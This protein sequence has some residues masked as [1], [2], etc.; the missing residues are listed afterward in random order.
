[1]PRILEALNAGVQIEVRQSRHAFE[2]RTGK[3][4]AAKFCQC[5]IK[6]CL[7]GPAHYTPALT[8]RF[9]Q[10]FRCC[11]RYGRDRFPS[12]EVDHSDTRLSNSWAILT[13]AQK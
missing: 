11:S 13:S 7:E 9:F 12:E 8:V 2:D 1:M 6:R 3:R 4:P 5:L 10:R